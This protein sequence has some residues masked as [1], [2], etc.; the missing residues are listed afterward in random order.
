MTEGE[1]LAC[2]DPQKMLHYIRSLRG[3]RLR[4]RKPIWFADYKQ[5]LA[6]R[7]IRLFYLA[8]CRLI[9][10]K[11]TDPMCQELLQLVEPFVETPPPTRYKEEVLAK[12]REKVIH[13]LDVP[14][15]TGAL[16]LPLGLAA[17]G[18][19]LSMGLKVLPLETREQD[20]DAVQR[21]ALHAG[22]Q[23]QCEFLRDIY[24]NPFRP[25]PPKTGKRRWQEQWQSCLA[26]NDEAVRKLAQAIYNNR[27]FDRLPKLANALEEAGCIDSDI[28]AH[29]RQAG[30]K[31][32][33]ILQHC[34]Q[35]SEHVRGCW[36][37]DLILGKE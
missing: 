3:A 22:A 6:P 30:C 17:A 32:D 2:T 10:Q 18:L 37:V 24:G 36:V 11:S 31:N 25:L 9:A 4:H 15:I 14:P 28:L 21:A 1:W 19:R 23:V 7:K 5:D 35:P 16:Y 34:R 12:F 8:C 33:D 20:K 13:S 27:Q 26:S 29:C